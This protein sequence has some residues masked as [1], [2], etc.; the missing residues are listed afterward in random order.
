MPTSYDLQ[1]H[2]NDTLAA[3]GFADVDEHPSIDLFVDMVRNISKV[4]QPGEVM[5][6][7]L[8]AMRQAYGESALITLSC[9]A[10]KPGHYKITRQLDYEG[11]NLASAVDPWLERDKLVTHTGGLLDEII[12]TPI[13]KLAHQLKVSDDPV[14]GDWLSP[15]KSMIAI[16]AFLDGVASNWAIILKKEPNAFSL[17]ELEEHIL[18]ANLIGSMVNNV[19]VNQQLRTLN[20]KMHHEVERIAEIQ[21]ALLPRT[22]PKITGLAV[23]ASYEAYDRAGGDMYDFV[24]LLGPGKEDETDPDGRWGIVV[25]DV[26]GHGPSATVVMAMLNAIL[27]SYPKTP[28]GPSDLLHYANKHLSS[29]K[30]QDS[31]ITGFF[32]IYDP[33][34]RHF[35]YARAGHP[36]ALLKSEGQ[37]MQRLEG[38]GG[39]PLGVMEE[40]EYQDTTVVLEPG[41]TIVIYTDGIEES[42]NRKG[43]QFGINGIERSLIHCSGEPGCSVSSINDALELHEEGQRPGDDQTIVALQVM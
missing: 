15:Y 5:Q 27:Y 17:R 20:D 4:D 28:E 34:T 40:A 2:R 21:R 11:N 39:L 9:K 32:A 31:F 36:P 37:P 19:V 16:P 8:Q 3:L 6:A 23:A 43:K 25:A 38:I 33:A 35:T 18:R 22:L 42:M 24:S 7:F 13:P 29:K 30:I 14:L 12:S 1:P 41:Q 26:S 10:L